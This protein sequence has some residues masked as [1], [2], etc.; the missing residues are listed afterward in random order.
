MT[1]AIFA[2]NKKI[3]QFFSTATLKERSINPHLKNWRFFIKNILFINISL[4]ISSCFR[5]YAVIIATS[6]NFDTLIIHADEKFVK[7][8]FESMQ[9]YRIK[10]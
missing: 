10:E 2:V 3:G 7:N 1:T 9:Q 4:F 6:P 8:V 5:F